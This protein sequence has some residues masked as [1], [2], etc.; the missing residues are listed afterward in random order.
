MASSPR[1]HCAMIGRFV[2]FGLRRHA[3][4]ALRRIL[5]RGEQEI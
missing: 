3:L 1:F 5:A 2:A 4:Y